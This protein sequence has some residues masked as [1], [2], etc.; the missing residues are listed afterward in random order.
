MRDICITEAGHRG[1]ASVG[2]SGGGGRSAE[3]QIKGR[4]VR[5]SS[6]AGAVSSRDVIVYL[7]TALGGYLE[8]KKNLDKNYVFCHD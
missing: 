7:R 4:A 1:G 6:R 2:I 3:G 5:L 8:Y